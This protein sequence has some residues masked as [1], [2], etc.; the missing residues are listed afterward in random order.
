[1]TVLTVPTVHL[2][3]TSREALYEALATAAE[4]V[5]QAVEALQATY[6]NGRDYYPQGS[7][8]LRQAEAEYQSRVE[9]VSAVRA[10]LMELMSAVQAAGR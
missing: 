7:G 1:M 4:A 2:N 10:E 3:G 5:Y 9:R 6:P 8:A